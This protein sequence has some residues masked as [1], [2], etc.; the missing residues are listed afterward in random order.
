MANKFPTAHHRAKA[1]IK[2]CAAS[3]AGIDFL[4]DAPN[5]RFTPAE[6]HGDSFAPN[7][8]HN[9]P[10][11]ARGSIPCGRGNVL[12]LKNW[13]PSKLDCSPMYG[14]YLTDTPSDEH[15]AKEQ[16][17][18]GNPKALRA[19]LAE[20]AKARADAKIAEVC[21]ELFERYAA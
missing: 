9:A 10:P 19:L 4:P 14:C 5:F 13:Q 16:W 2:A 18:K 17:A 3:G 12:K 20:R 21:D 11:S 8:L 15:H 1:I 7:D 6:R